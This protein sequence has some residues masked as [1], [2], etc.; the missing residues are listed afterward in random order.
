MSSIIF[1]IFENFLSH[2][3]IDFLLLHKA[4]HQLIR[5]AHDIRATAAKT[6]VHTVVIGAACIGDSDF[7]VL[8]GDDVVAAVGRFD[9][10]FLIHIQTDGAQNLTVAED[11]RS[12]RILISGEN[13]IA[14]GGT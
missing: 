1:G 13:K 8:N 12:V 2:C 6:A 14:A 11:L 5:Q 7:S 9:G 3:R 4:D 10:K